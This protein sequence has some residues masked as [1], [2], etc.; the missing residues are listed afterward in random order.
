MKKTL[1]IAEAGVNHNGSFEIAM[2]LVDA[3][4]D[5]GAD[6]IKFQTFSAAK[7][8]TKQAKK[9][10]Y[11][12]ENTK[13][14]NSQLDMLE[15][16]ELSYD[17]QKK[18]KDYCISKNIEFL[19]TAFDL[20]SLNFL[21]D[22]GINR[23]KIP[24]GEITNLPYL[25]IIGSKNI[26]TILSTGMSNLSDIEG[27]VNVIMN[28]GLERKKLTIL[29][30]TTQYPVPISEVNLNCLKTLKSAFLTDVGYSD[31]TESTSIPAVAVAI[32]AKVIEKHI[33]L[34]NNMNG[35]DHKASLNPI[36]FKQ[37]VQNIREIEQAMGSSIKEPS[38]SEIENIKSVRKSIVA[39]KRINIGEQFSNDN[40]T[41]KRP[42]TGISPMLIDT[43]IGRVSNICYEEDDL[44][45][46]L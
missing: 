26:P 18:I 16:L 45:Q 29:H 4:K 31:H 46:Y 15:R 13:N 34:D 28:S 17:Q 12:I 9:A 22:L 36:K 44:I 38:L 21:F 33:T 42:G 27:A 10:S 7:L 37:M 23:V 35:P 11:Q 41:V 6:I 40:L 3:A 2:K 25:R 5:C 1:I 32:G 43:L 39:S 8:V 24:S 20:E 30:C 19:S 14:N